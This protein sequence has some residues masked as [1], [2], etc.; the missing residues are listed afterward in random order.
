MSE[1]TKTKHH[2]RSACTSLPTRMHPSFSAYNKSG[3]AQLDKAVAVYDLGETVIAVHRNFDK[4]RSKAR[5]LKEYIEERQSECY[6]DLDNIVA[7][8]QTKEGN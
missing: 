7:A 8:S 5:L 3:N 4:Q 2:S 6:N 1:N